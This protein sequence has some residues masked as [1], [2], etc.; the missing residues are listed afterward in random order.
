VIICVL[1]RILR[2]LVLNERASSSVL[3]AVCCSS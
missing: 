2:E 1:L 3:M